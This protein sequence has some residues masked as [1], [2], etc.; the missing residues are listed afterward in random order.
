MQSNLSNKYFTLLSQQLRLHFAPQAQ[1]FW[2]QLQ[3]AMA[4]KLNGTTAD[5][6]SAKARFK[7]WLLIFCG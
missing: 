3:M 1:L 4:C 2:Q 7:L 5:S 6:Q